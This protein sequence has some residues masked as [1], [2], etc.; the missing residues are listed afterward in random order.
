[1]NRSFV[2]KVENSPVIAAVRDEEEFRQSLT[3]DVGVVFLLGCDIVSLPER[4][5]KIR[6]AGKVPVVHLDLVSGLAQREEAVRYIHE[7]TCAEGIITTRANLIP[8]AEYMGL[9]TIQRVFMLDGMALDSIIRQTQKG[10]PVPDL[11]EILPG[12]LAPKVM[13]RIG[14]ELRIPFICG[15][16]IRDR[17]DVVNALDAGALAVSASDMEIWKM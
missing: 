5:E 11:F 9:G 12:V 8:C 2:E 16:L 3:S 4:T 7:K 17:E 15:G 10:G 6:D 13:K 14:R 1:M